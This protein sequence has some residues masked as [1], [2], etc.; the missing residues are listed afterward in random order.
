MNDN[1]KNALLKE[2]DKVIIYD[3]QGLGCIK[4]TKEIITAVDNSI[5]PY[6]QQQLA[7]MARIAKNFIYNVSQLIH[8]DNI[9][10]FVLLEQLKSLENAIK[11]A[12][13]NYNE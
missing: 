12:E 4:S 1:Q 6:Y 11:L 5:I 7:G 3:K 10:N 13:E 8:G 2:L 9:E